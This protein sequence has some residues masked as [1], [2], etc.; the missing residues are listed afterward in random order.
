[1]FEW[2][3]GLAR[4][5]LAV[6][7]NWAAWM[8]GVLMTLV[9]VAY[10]W[11]GMPIPRRIGLGLAIAFFA[12]AIFNAWRD[13]YRSKMAA[14]TRLE[15]L[16]KPRI[17]PEIVQSNWHEVQ[18]ETSVV[19]VVSVK[20][21]GAPSIVDA[22]FLTATLNDGRKYPAVQYFFPEFMTLVGPSGTLT[23]YGKDAIEE[24]T[25][26]IPIEHNGKRTGVLWF[27]FPTIPFKD[28]S[29]EGTE[30]TLS[31]RDINGQIAET[32]AVIHPGRHDPL[33][34]PAGITRPQSKDGEPTP[35]QQ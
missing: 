21:L 12:I 22:Y 19:L 6:F 2:F 4:F 24:K 27:R 1:M 13:E 20:N 26:A 35:R 30:L 17:V 8:G 7:S 3:A 25:G 10:L 28:F 14:E 32:S 5:L 34:F 16:T 15:G 18:G 29:Q 23:Y 31:T 11:R 9:G 33:T